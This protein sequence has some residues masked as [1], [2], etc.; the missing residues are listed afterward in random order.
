VHTTLYPVIM[1]LIILHGAGMLVQ[2]PQFYYY[3]LGPAIL[4]MIDV[5]L[6]ISHTGYY[7]AIDPT[8]EVLKYNPPVIK[9]ILKRPFGWTYRAGQHAR[10]SCP[11][12]QLGR[13]IGVAARDKFRPFT[14]SSAPSE[15]TVSFH[16]EVH[17]VKRGGSGW[18]ENLMEVIERTQKLS[19]PFPPVLIDGPY[20]GTHQHYDE[21]NKALVLFASGIGMTPFA[22]IVKD[23]LFKMK[24]AHAVGRPLD[25]AKVYMLWSVRELKQT[26]WFLS[27]LKEIDE[28]DEHNI[29][30]PALFVSRSGGKS[31]VK[32]AP[33][34]I[35]EK[36]LGKHAPTEGE[37]PKTFLTG[38][39]FRIHFER[40]PMQKMITKISKEFAGEKFGCYA[41]GGPGFLAGLRKA[42]GGAG[43]PFGQLH[44][45]PFY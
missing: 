32:L 41:C 6:R 35:L 15:S 10:I 39:Q 27:A 34:Y 22:S 43:R 16:I 13:N 2:E 45:E 40:M 21:N 7:A 42:Y 11:A 24:V 1:L 12:A 28:Q 4:F 25:L 30:H 8:T 36:W 18:T 44:D 26:S 38:T 23:L 17:P 20:G 33:L 3:F 5:L 19:Q 29:V 9:L 37:L 14:I 31:D